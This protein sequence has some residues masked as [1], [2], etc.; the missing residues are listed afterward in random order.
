MPYTCTQNTYAGTVQGSNGVAF[1]CMYQKQID[2][3]W[4]GYGGSVM[5]LLWGLRD[6]EHSGCQASSCCRGLLSMQLE[7][8]P[9]SQYDTHD[10]QAC[11]QKSCRV[12][13]P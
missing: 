1:Q 2:L 9:L 10:V 4:Q 7:L 3:C 13:L 5:G 6:M 11:M 8:C 12:L